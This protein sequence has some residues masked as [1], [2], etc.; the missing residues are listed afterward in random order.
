MPANFKKITKI[1]FS[2]RLLFSK[3]A[4]FNGIPRCPRWF[5][6][7][8][9]NKPNNRHKTVFYYIQVVNRKTSTHTCIAPKYPY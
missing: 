1:D 6:A 9:L 5:S 7:E 4:D 8:A 2:Y 3:L